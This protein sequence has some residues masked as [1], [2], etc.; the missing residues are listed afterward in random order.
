MGEQT[1]NGSAGIPIAG[2]EAEYATEL[3]LDGPSAFWLHPEGP[4]SDKTPDEWQAERAAERK[5]VA[6]NP[7]G[8]YAHL[9]GLQQMPANQ[10]S[11]YQQLMNA[12][13]GQLV[14]YQQHQYSGLANMLGF[15]IF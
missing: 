13:P 12:Q 9:A 4:L 10:L 14:Q 6:N 3:W 1:I 15:R 7:L 5:A 11:L 8:Q 2:R